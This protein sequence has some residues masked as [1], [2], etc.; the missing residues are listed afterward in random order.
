M[1]CLFTHCINVSFLSLP[2]SSPSPPHNFSLSPLSPLLSCSICLYLSLS[3]SRRAHTVTVLF[4]LTCVL[5]YVT[6]LEETPQDTAYNT[7]RLVLARTHALTRD[8]HRRRGDVRQ[9]MDVLSG[10][11]EGLKSPNKHSSC[12]SVRAL[13]E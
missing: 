6:L 5:V 10:A 2:S 12:Q 3:L 11:G 13:L 9:C 1:N 4:I 7:K 8:T